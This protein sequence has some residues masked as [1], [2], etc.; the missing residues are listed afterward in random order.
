VSDWLYGLPVFGLVVVVFAATYAVA[1]AIYAAVSVLAVGERGRAL[2][3]VSPGMLPPLALVFGLLVGFLAAQVWND[4]ERARGA[5]HR[6]AS[7]LRA[8]VLLAANFP[9]PPEAQLRALI[10]RHIQEAVTQEWPAMTRHEARLTMIPVPLA[11]A[12]HL[13]LALVP[14]SDGQRIA[15]REIV[16]S[17]Q[18]A[19]DARRQR[20]IISQSGI[21]WVKWTGLIAEAILSLLAIACVHSDNR[22]TSAVA[23]AIFAS[24]V[25]VSVVLIAS[26]ARPFA[27]QLS[28]MPDLLLQVMPSGR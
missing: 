13:T 28:V 12:V 5:V 11:E 9:G 2:K 23:L 25:G 3:A 6:E 17:L 27:G 15:Q 8:V 7:A 16:A 14:A 1:G 22:V 21:N 19:L 26:Q 10:Q 20:I 24:A 4:T 18:E